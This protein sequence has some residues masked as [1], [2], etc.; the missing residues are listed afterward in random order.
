MFRKEEGV[1]K[2]AMSG[3]NRDRKHETHLNEKQS[4]VVTIPTTPEAA[5]LNLCFFRSSKTSLERMDGGQDALGGQKH[6]PR[7]V[8]W[9]SF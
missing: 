2:F 5:E 4:I 8:F 3:E 9:N 1:K 7:N 6:R